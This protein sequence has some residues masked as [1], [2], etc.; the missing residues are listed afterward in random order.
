[1]LWGNG[2][3]LKES[4]QSFQLSSYSV[5]FFGEG[6]STCKVYKS[7]SAKMEF[8]GVTK[9]EM[10]NETCKLLVNSVLPLANPCYIRL[11]KSV[12]IEWE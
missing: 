5:T 11:C 3:K 10:K 7:K 1:M 8:E 12:T 6:I 9:A 4:S 2:G